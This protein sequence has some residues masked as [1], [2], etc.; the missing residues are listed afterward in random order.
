MPFV[1]TP[2]GWRPK[3]KHVHVATGPGRTGRETETGLPEASTSNIS[4]NKPAAPCDI[5]RFVF[6]GIHAAKILVF[7][8]L[9][10]I[11][12]RKS[13]SPTEPLGLREPY[14]CDESRIEER[15]A[16]SAML[17]SREHSD[18]AREGAGDGKFEK[19]SVSFPQSFP[20]E[21]EM[22]V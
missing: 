17:S 22:P 12:R 5:V 18:L 7:G 10:D 13:L 3:G 6:I 15:L 8:T 14:E 1:P 11:E 21:F 20:D 9:F 16:R 2:S 19:N 4:N